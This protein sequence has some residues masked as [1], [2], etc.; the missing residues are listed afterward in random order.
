[1]K[2]YKKILGKVMM[3]A[4]GTYNKDKK[5]EPIS[6]VTDEETN[7]SYISRK[8][9]PAGIQINNRE[10]W[11]PVASSGIID[12]GVI[13]LNRKNKDGQVPI[14]DLKSAAESVAIGDRRAGVI[15]G[16]L[17][18]NAETDTV[19]SW[20]LYQYNDVSPSNW[21]NIQ[22]WLPIDYTNKYAGWYDDAQS[23]YASYPFPKVGMY[24]YVGNSASSAVVYRCYEDSLW[25]P[26]EDKAFTGVVNLADEEDITSKQNKLKFKDKEYNPAQFTGMGRVILRKNLVDVGGGQ[27]KNVLTQDMINKS[28]TIYEIRYDFDLNGKEITIPEGCV[29]DFQGGNLSNGT[30]IGDNTHLKADVCNIFKEIKID[31]TWNVS[32]IYSS[33]FDFNGSENFDNASN[34][35]N[36]INLSDNN[37]HNNIYINGSYWTSVPDK[38]YENGGT[39]NLKSNTNLYINGTIS[40]I[41]NSYSHYRL[42]L[43][44]K[45]SN[46]HIYNGVLIGDVET[47]TGETG[48]WGYG[49][50][51]NSA[52]NCSIHNT[53]ISL[54]W[55]DGIDI[56]GVSNSMDNICSNILINNCNIHNC[57]RQGISVEHCQ[58]SIIQN[59]TINDIGNPKNTP[60]T[61]AID[62]EPYNDKVC[63]NIQVINCITSGC[64][65]PKVHGNVSGIHFFNVKMNGALVCTVNNGD[66]IYENCTI[67]EVVNLKGTLNGKFTFLNCVL[68][69]LAV[70][71]VNIDC[72]RCDFTAKHSSNVW[73]T[74]YKNMISC[75]EVEADDVNLY[76]VNLYDCSFDFYCEKTD[77]HAGFNSKESYNNYNLNFYNCIVNKER[78][79]ISL[80]NLGNLYDCKIYASR[81]YLGANGSNTM[82]IHNCIYTTEKY[83]SGAITL[84]RFTDEGI[85]GKDI[86]SIKNLW[87]NNAFPNVFEIYSDTDFSDV[88]ILVDGYRKTSDFYT[89]DNDFKI[90]E[91]FLSHRIRVLE[92]RNIRRVSADN[93]TLNYYDI[94]VMYYNSST[95][96]YRFWQGEHW[97]GIDGR[98]DAKKNGTT[99]ERPSLNLP[100]DIGFMYYD[101]TIKKPIFYIGGNKWVDATGAEV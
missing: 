4:E 89:Q 75:N 95:N 92:E 21:T 87:V 77:S 24:A 93:P 30:L 82:N 60:P 15:L 64:Y 69:L 48:E 58:N 41:A 44:E 20:K 11:Q 22:Y 26:T 36:L 90:F 9:V 98:T 62:I 79:E 29:L 56:D 6:L 38:Y 45:A 96:S 51:F 43:V 66:C 86:Y 46:V 61:A 83:S 63:K 31:G 59:C 85:T 27:V 32:N 72:N 67:T 70:K 91:K 47:H 100:E 23:L 34:F 57:R 35:K 39:L 101:K 68:P 42:I 84:I 10:Y 55:G 14:Y 65:A 8:D 50:T 54:M 17:G 80:W 18:F 1:M 3:T 52:I 37:I 16:F 94:G 25:T 49:V 7:K 53:E 13:I 71:S 33:W 78:R 73:M 97:L 81:L 2:Q 28:N 99:E 5:Y 12:N 88:S 19:P 40:I 76:Q 74:N